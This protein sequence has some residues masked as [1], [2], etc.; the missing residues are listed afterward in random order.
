MLVQAAA[1]GQAEEASPFWTMA[2]TPVTAP[3]ASPVTPTPSAPTP[4]AWS[5]VGRPVAAALGATAAPTRSIA[6]PGSTASVVCI[7]SLSLTS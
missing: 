1:F 7:D 5:T 2:R 3:M 4:T 6:L